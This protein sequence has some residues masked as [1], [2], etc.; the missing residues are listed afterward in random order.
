MSLAESSVT[1]HH[2][3]LLCWWNQLHRHNT[4]ISILFC[5]FN[6]KIFKINYL[7]QCM[8][9]FYVLGILVDNVTYTFILQPEN[10]NS[11]EYTY[12]FLNPYSCGLSS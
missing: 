7:P 10:F 11:F 5:Y 6:S 4:N 2:V 9:I 3:P 12:I 8:T 1:F